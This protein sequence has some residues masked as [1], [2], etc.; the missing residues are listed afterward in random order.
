MY[1]MDLTGKVA[2]VTGGAN[3]IGKAIADALMDCGAKVAVVDM[4]VHEKDSNDRIVYVPADVSKSDQVE[5]MIEKVTEHFGRLDILV[6][7]AGISTMDYFVDM[8][9]SDW[10][11]TMDVNAK[12]VYL[13]MQAAAKVL[14]QQGNGG[15]IIN[16]ASQAGK[17]GYQLMG[18]YVASKHAV[19]GMTK[20]AGLELAKDKIN[21]N[22]ICPGIVE[23]EMK[24]TERVIGGKLRKVDAAA[25]KQEDDSQVP[26]GR[27]GTPED[28]ANVAVFLASHFSDYMT[29]QGINVTGGMTMN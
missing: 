9:E 6:N 4:A 16:I 21:V 5:K 25:I 19:L 27:T 15:K 10:D 13:C 11:K 18:S 22:A 2:I 8:K 28:I 26:L 29:G 17:N 1:T 7:N 24:Q 20:V 3:G 12:G 14:K 23:T